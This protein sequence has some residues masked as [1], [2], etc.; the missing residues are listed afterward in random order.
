MSRLALTLA[1]HLTERQQR[2]A[3]I[4]RLLAEDGFVAKIYH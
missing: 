4:K 3:E 1:P 2:I